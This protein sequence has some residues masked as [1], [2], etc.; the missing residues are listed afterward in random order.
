MARPR[1]LL[2]NHEFTMTG[3]SRMMQTLAGVLLAD[4][5]TVDVLPMNP[6]PGPMRD[7]FTDLGVRIL[8]KFEPADYAMVIANSVGSCPFVARYG[9]QLPVA[10]RLAEVEV[11]REL[12]LRGWKVGLAAFGAARAIVFQTELQKEIYGTFLWGTE[13]EQ[14]VIPNA[15][16]PAPAPVPVPAKTG[17]RIVGIGTVDNRKRHEDTILAVERL[18][19][20]LRDRIEVVIIGKIFDLE[21]DAQRVVDANPKRYRLLGERSNAETLSWLAS[22]DVF[23]LPSLSESF[24]V[25][26]LEAMRAGK[27]VCLGDLPAYRAWGLRHGVNAVMH[28]P[29]DIDFLT[30]NLMLLLGHPVLARR[31]GETGRRLAAR[32]SL[33]AF[34]HEWLALIHRH[35]RRQGAPHDAPGAAPSHADDA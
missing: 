6:D 11:G 31:I 17:L 23:V 15:L 30:F 28:P 29:R 22:A 34:R 9:P 32:Y 12:L 27:P 24:G 8:T 16:A 18:P 3:A 19:Q 14:R 1:I 4:G 21:K 33:D 25:A 7:A 5:F 35:L 13:A 2:V 20:A 10:W 26:I